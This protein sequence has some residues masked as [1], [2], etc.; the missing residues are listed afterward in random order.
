MGLQLP[1][2]EFIWECEGLFPHTLCTP[3]SMWCDSRV[4]FLARHLTTL[5]LGSEPKVRVATVFVFGLFCCFVGYDEGS[6]VSWF[7][8]WKT[9]L[10]VQWKLFMRFVNYSFARRLARRFLGNKRMRLWGVY[11]TLAKEYKGGFLVIKKAKW[12]DF[13]EY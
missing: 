8:W 1:P 3:R 13:L 10:A 4:S 12:L 11:L 5:C 7:L 6:L 9:I 2:W